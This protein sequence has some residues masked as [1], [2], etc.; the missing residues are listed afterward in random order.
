MTEK[1]DDLIKS[2][3]MFLEVGGSPEFKIVA[4]MDVNL[5]LDDVLEGS[6]VRVGKY[7]FEFIRDRFIP[8]GEYYIVRAGL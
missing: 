6:R 5:E 8:L 4:A 7:E 3:E 2:I 1:R